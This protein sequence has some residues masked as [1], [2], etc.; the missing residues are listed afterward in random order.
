MDHQKRSLWLKR[1]RRVSEIIEVGSA[2]DFV[3]RAY[4]F[5][6]T[7][8]VIINLIVTVM[9]TFNSMEARFGPQL[10]LIEKLT[11]FAKYSGCEFETSGRYE[12]WEYK[13]NSHLRELY[14]ETYE[15]VCGKKPEVA[16]IHAGLECAV[17][18]A[19]IDG[20]DCI[21]IGPDMFGVHTTEEKLS[22]E[23]TQKIFNLLCKVL[24]KS[25]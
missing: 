22:I 8:I 10:L 7:A 1:R 24:E 18:A 3:S 15:E 23:S 2:D 12:P 5:T 4:D 9:Y 21:A 20:L 13:E 6:G 14:I 11:V 17:F 19:A 25:K 16:A